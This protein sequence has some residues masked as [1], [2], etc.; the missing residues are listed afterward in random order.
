M[1]L[2]ISAAIAAIGLL[3]SFFIFVITR[4]LVDLMTYETFDKF[5]YFF[6]AAYY[7]ADILN[8]FP[9]IIFFIAF[10]ISQKGTKAE[11][12]PDAPTLHY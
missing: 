4:A 2:K 7:V 3:I 10:F 12:Q 6:R 5:R 8:Y 1:F 9:L 11:R